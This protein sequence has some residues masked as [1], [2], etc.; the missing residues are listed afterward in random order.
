MSQI[1]QVFERRQIERREHALTEWRKLG[2]RADDRKRLETAR[3]VE[4]KRK[5]DAARRVNS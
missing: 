1:A 3:L 5:F 4:W 2:R